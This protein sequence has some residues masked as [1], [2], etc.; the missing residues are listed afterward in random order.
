MTPEQKQIIHNARAA[1]QRGEI[2]REQLHDVYRIV[3]RDMA[4]KA[5]ERMTGCFLKPNI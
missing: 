3:A 4:E 5:L 1:Y 2:T